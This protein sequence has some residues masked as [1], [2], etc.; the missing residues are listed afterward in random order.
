[1]LLSILL[2]KKMNLLKCKLYFSYFLFRGFLGG[3]RI[4]IFAICVSR[5]NMRLRTKLFQSYLRQ[6][7]GFFDTHESGKL[8]SRLNLDTQ[9]MSS[10]VANNIAQCIGAFVKFSKFIN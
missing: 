5:L 3:F 8:L 4:G 10:T 7:I 2:G 9:I 6:E 1:M